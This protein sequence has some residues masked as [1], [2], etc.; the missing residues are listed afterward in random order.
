VKVAHAAREDSVYLNACANPVVQLESVDAI[1][2]I[3]VIAKR[4]T[5]LVLVINSSVILNSARDVL[6]QTKEVYAG[7]I[8]FS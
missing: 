7:I 1:A 6:T 5:V 2:R 4:K 3:K 8:K